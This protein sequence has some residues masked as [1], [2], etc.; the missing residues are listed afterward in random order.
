[1]IKELKK[2]AVVAINSN[3][4][5]WTGFKK[6][7]LTLQHIKYDGDIA[8]LYYQDHSGNFNEDQI[9]AIQEKGI[10]LI[11]VQRPYCSY[12][13]FATI[14]KWRRL[15]NYD[16][17]LFSD[18]ADVWFQRSLDTYFKYVMDNNAF[19]YT[20][21]GFL[22]REEACNKGWAINMDCEASEYVL[23]SPVINCG[24]MLAPMKMFMPLAYIVG[25]VGEKL[26]MDQIVVGIL[27]AIY[28]MKT[29]EDFCLTSYNPFSHKKY[30][31]KDDKVCHPSGSPFAIIHQNAGR[32]LKEDGT[33]TGNKYET[34]YMQILNKEVAAWGDSL[35]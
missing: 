31:F 29:I 3:E 26:D 17:I 21:E 10:F 27:N 14:A 34:N 28:P 18:G 32:S 6:W 19:L 2:V 16:V 33:Y 7:Y 8:V 24:V 5:A 30:I 22:H 12:T 11:R 15:R 1:M 4:R 35:H 23:D 20:D 25:V 13:R 9:R